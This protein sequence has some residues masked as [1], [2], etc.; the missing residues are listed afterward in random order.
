MTQNIVRQRINHQIRGVHEVRLVDATGKM[1]GIVSFQEALGQ[2]HA[3]G[4]DLV[5]MN[6][7]N[8]PPVCKILDYGKFK[9][10][11]SKAQ[12]QARKNQFV[13]ETKELT[14]RPV[15]DTH[16]LLVKAGHVK[17][18]LED[19]DR[20]QVVV[21]LKGREK[22]HPEQ[23]TE[24]IKKLLLSVGPHKVEAQPRADGRNV[25]A[26]IGPV[27]VQHPARLTPKA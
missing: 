20:V 26:T 15:T 10:E 5:E 17:E 8:N 14:L 6:R 2:A 7:N 21:R 3:Q 11:Q 1:V 22:A 19:G 12:K 23:A 24:I 25:T 18:W 9:Y 13:Q 27:Q 4:L 16:D